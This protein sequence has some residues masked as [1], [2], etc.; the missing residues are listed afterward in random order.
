MG[1]CVCTFRHVWETGPIVA[2]VYK[3][4]ISDRNITYILIYNKINGVCL[5]AKE[6]PNI[7]LHV[8]VMNSSLI[9]MITPKLEDT[10]SIPIQT[11][12]RN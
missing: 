10:L 1:L 9:I 5:P 7:P 6:I 4:Q 2:N 12:F 8:C 11:L 3:T